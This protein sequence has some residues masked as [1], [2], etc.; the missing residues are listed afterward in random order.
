MKPQ[1]P[2]LIPRRTSCT[3]FARPYLADR[4]VSGGGRHA[5]LHMELLLKRQSRYI[6][7]QNNE[8]GNSNLVFSTSLLFRLQNHFPWTCP[9]VIY[10]LLFQTAAISNN[11]SLSLRVWNTGIQ[12]YF[13]TWALSYSVPIN[14]HGSSGLTK[15]ADVID[16][17]LTLE[18]SAFE[19]LYGG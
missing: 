1:I 6:E 17:G 4:S 2:C 10:Y 19:S 13:L 12:L 16:E 5:Y 9:S 18:T 3:C 15:L 14:L 11:F 8:K 7:S